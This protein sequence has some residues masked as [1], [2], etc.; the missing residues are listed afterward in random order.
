MVH[1]KVFDP[2]FDKFRN[3]PNDSWDKM[4]QVLGNA[5]DYLIGDLA[6]EFFRL[7]PDYIGKVKADQLNNSQR[8]FKTLFSIH[9]K[10]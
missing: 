1:H 8:V 2:F 6:D 9:K 10:A 5:F 3:D 4:S 7:H